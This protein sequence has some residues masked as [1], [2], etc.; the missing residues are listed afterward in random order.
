MYQPLAEQWSRGKVQRFEAPVSQ[1]KGPSSTVPS[2]SLLPHCQPSHLV[3]TSSLLRRALDRSL[4]ASSKSRQQVQSADQ[5]GRWHTGSF[6]KS[7][8]SVFI[9]GD[10]RVDSATGFVRSRAPAGG[11]TAQVTE[12]G[13]DTGSGR[14]AGVDNVA[15]PYSIIRIEEICSVF[16]RC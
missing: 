2:Q 7:T 12:G 14:V 4:P 10:E 16:R 9:D 15:A 13:Q 8:Y 11:L 6:Q 1:H 3:P 5:Q